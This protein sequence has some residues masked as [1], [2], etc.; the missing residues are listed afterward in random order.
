MENNNKKI[1]IIPDYH[2]DQTQYDFAECKKEQKM[3]VRMISLPS[4]GVIP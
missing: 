2:V 1:L 4:T 3:V